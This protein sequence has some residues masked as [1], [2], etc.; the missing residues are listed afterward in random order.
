MDRDERCVKRMEESARGL[1]ARVGEVVADVNSSSLLRTAIQGIH[2]DLS[3]RLQKSIQMNDAM[4]KENVK[5]ERDLVAIESRVSVLEDTIRDG[6]RQHQWQQGQIRHL[7]GSLGRVSR[8]PRLVDTI[9]DIEMDIKAE[10]DRI[11]DCSQC[12]IPLAHCMIA[13]AHQEEEVWDAKIREYDAQVLKTTE[14]LNEMRLYMHQIGLRGFDE[15]SVKLHEV[16]GSVLSPSQE[17]SVREQFEDALE[18]LLCRLQEENQKL[19]IR[20]EDLVYAQMIVTSGIQQ[21]DAATVAVEHEY[22]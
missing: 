9:S 5:V 21:M 22:V 1:V 11:R 8:I 15:Y 19:H 13:H 12:L 14:D 20:G 6:M 17:K 7:A 4:E 18:R 3:A 16:D 2:Q 10:E